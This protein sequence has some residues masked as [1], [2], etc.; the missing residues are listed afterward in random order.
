MR[1]LDY[2]SNS[3]TVL[4]RG[5][6]GGDGGNGMAGAKGADNTNVPTERDPK[7]G[8]SVKALGK[9]VTSRRECH[10]HCWCNANCCDQWDTYAVGWTDQVTG[11]PGGRGENGGDGTP[12]QNGSPG[13]NGHP[14]GNGGNGGKGGDGGDVTVSLK[15]ITIN[16]QWIGW[17]WWSWWNGA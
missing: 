6:E 11:N 14:G 5:G 17:S 16:V 3:M 8:D 9:F 15:A 13:Q 2:S 4:A 12:G 1:L 10:H 7:N